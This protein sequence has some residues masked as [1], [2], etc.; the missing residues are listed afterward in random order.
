MPNYLKGK[1]EN[2]VKF[3]IPEGYEIRQ[4]ADKLEKQGLVDKEKFLKLTSDKNISRRVSNFKR[5]RGWTEF[6]RISFSIYL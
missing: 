1:D 4:I 6:R 5:V 2:V 3:T